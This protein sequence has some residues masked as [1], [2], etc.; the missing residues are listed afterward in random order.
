MKNLRNSVQIIGNVGN[1]PAVVELQGGNWVAR[2][3]VATHENIKTAEGK[4]AST[5]WHT[6]VAWGNTAKYAEKHL[7]KGT[8]VAIEGKLVNRSWEGK[9]GKKHESTEIKA[10]EIL[11]TNKAVAEDSPTEKSK[12]EKKPKADSKKAA[13]D[14]N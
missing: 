1:A 6:V 7:L 12:V 2:F 11:L 13:L 8:S 5:Q 9:D 3:S 14:L 10:N 4:K